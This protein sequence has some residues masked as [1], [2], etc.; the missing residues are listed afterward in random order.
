MAGEERGIDVTK[1]ANVSE[2][3]A[4]VASDELIFSDF[5][6][7]FLENRMLFKN[8]SRE[9]NIQYRIYNVEYMVI[10]LMINKIN[11]NAYKRVEISSRRLSENHSP[12]KC[13]LYTV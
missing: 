8:H 11:T 10:E 9:Y 7:I 1:L 2:A 3:A 12:A 13:T 4:A 5:G 6:R